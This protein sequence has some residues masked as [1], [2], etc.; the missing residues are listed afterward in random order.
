MTH[1]ARLGALLL[2]TLGLCVSVAAVEPG[3]P[4]PPFV[5]SELEGEGAV[6]LADLAG[7]VVLLDFWASW[8]AP[9]RE[10][11]P[12]Y[13]GLH[14]ELWERGLAV[15][16]VNVDDRLDDARRFVDERALLQPMLRDADG[17][18][19]RRFG[20]SVM[21]AAFVMDR[22]GVV[23][24]AHVGFDADHAAETRAL[25]LD[26]LAQPAATSPGNPS[27]TRKEEVRP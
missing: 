1:A 3:D 6:A 13:S 23:R 17:E 12:Y 21:P 9:C 22:R 11:L 19:A 24:M 2:G 15:L 16:A 5:L 27:S 20:V 4:A 14:D 8:C 25:I 26:L 10:A 18:V 7:Q